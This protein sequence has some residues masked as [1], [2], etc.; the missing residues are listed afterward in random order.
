MFT[1]P[2]RPEL[3]S[4]FDI[5]SVDVGSGVAEKQRAARL[6]PDRHG[7]AYTGLRGECPEH[8]SGFGLE[9]VDG[10]VLAA[11]EETSARDRRLLPR[12][13]R[14]RKTKCPLKWEQ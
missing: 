5:Q 12:G 13:G 11:D 14:L 9:R 6:R 2:P 3:T 7:G 4:G 1:D 10:A 8:A